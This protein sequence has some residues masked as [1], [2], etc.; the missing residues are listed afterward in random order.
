MPRGEHGH[1]ARSN[2]QRN[3]I[4]RCKRPNRVSKKRRERSGKPGKLGIVRL[5]G[6]DLAQLRRECY[7]RDEGKCQWDGCGKSVPF[8]GDLYTRGHMAHVK[9]KRM[10]GDTL[11]NVRWLCYEHHILV[12]HGLKWSGGRDDKYSPEVSSGRIG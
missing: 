2:R 11:D 8:E 9:N 6:D 10:Y 12:E 3:P 7:E 5:Y 4:A 1:H